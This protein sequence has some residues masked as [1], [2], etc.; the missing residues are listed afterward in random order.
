MPVER[1]L[2][3]GQVVPG[4]EDVVHRLPELEAGFHL[5]CQEGHLAPRH[6]QPRAGLGEPG[7]G[8]G[9]RRLGRVGIAL[10]GARRAPLA[11]VAHEGGLVRASAPLFF[12]VGAFALMAHLGARGAPPSA[13]GVADAAL[14]A[15]PAVYAFVRGSRR[16]AVPV[17]SPIALELAR[18]ARRVDIEFPRHVGYRPSL[19]DVV[20]YRDPHLECEMGVVL[21]CR[22]G[23]TAFPAAG[24]AGL[25]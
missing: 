22:H 16:S 15:R 8:L 9:L 1:A 19:G 25:A 14:L 24:K 23:L 13:V 17:V 7:V 11:A 6:V 4:G 21:R 12:E 20:L 10:E 2:R 5:S 18:D 3:A